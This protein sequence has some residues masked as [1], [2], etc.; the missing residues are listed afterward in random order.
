MYRFVLKPRWIL[1]HLFVLLI[2]AG[3]L[4]AGFWQLGRWHEKRDLIHRYKELSAVPVVPVGELISMES[5]P[6]QIQEL[7]LRQVQVRGHYLADEQV[8]VRNRTY[9][10]APGFYVLTPLLMPSGQAVV[11][12]RGWVPYSIGETAEAMQA[13]APPTGEVVVEG[14][15]TATQS[16]GAFGATDP[17]EGHLRE[18]AR[19]DIARIAHQV[20]APVLPAYVTLEAQS[21][22][23]G[24]VPVMV[25]AAPPD[26]GPH[27][28]Y[29]VQWFIFTSIALGGYP[30][31][32]RKVARERAAG[33]KGSALRPKRSKL[34]PVDD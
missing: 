2:V 4:I 12:N 17:A 10:G 33:Q 3:C 9:E 21:P 25:E 32:L 31:I 29:A 6:E 16:K 30:L 18:L 7:T 19:A 20:D 5:T 26:E 27:R 8:T 23:P 13:A 34:V 15:V 11:I 28:D 24:D 1:S 22:A 14:T